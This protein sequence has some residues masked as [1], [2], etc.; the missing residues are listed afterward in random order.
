MFI[1]NIT[2]LNFI[3]RLIRLQVKT[4]TAYMLF[5]AVVI[6]VLLFT[7]DVYKM[8]T[9]NQILTYEFSGD[10]TNYTAGFVRRGLLGTI[11]LQVS[12]ICQP[13]VFLLIVSSYALLFIL[14]LILSRMVTLRVKLSYI[15][16]VILSPSLILMHRGEE[17]FRTD[18]II[19]ALNFTVSC[20]LLRLIFHTRNEIYIQN[21]ERRPSFFRMLVIDSII[22]MILSSSALINEISITLLPPVIVLFF[23]YSKRIHRTLH[24]LAVFSTLSII[25]VVMMKCFKFSDPKV[26][27]ESW[28]RV[29]GVDDN[30]FVFKDSNGLLAVTD[31]VY[32][33]NIANDALSKFPNL[34]IKLIFHMFLAV[35]IPF[36]IIL[37]SRIEVFHSAS[38]RFRKAKYLMIISCLAPISL[39]VIAWD[40]GRW[41]SI[42]AIQLTVYSLL[43]A[44]KDRIAEE[45]TWLT[46]LTNATKQCFAIVTMAVLINYE[47]NWNG[48]F[49]KSNQM[50]YEQ[51][52]QAIRNFPD[53]GR[54]TM[55]L[56]TKEL[57]MKP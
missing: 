20:F 22:F 17:F 1:Q 43:L 31:K 45:R 55:K 23:I 51:T 18:G 5:T 26:I 29:L 28:S 56:L 15:L 49:H 7:L 13:F 10:M 57:I 35:F 14:Y 44:H 37:L 50:F 41:F 21:D 25:Y 30:P 54:L 47:L 39:S 40:Y 12:D 11:M 16:A 2:R 52:A 36:I 24:F 32:A 38:S 19:M 48:Y 27:V 4:I 34:P 33:L 6:I 53:L 8:L 42:A 9:T 46:T 3:N